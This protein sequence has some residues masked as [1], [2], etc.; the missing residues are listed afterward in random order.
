MRESIW[1]GH[2]YYCLL[3]APNTFS[4][5]LLL[6]WWFV[7]ST[8]LMAGLVC[9]QV[10][11]GSTSC[12]NLDKNFHIELFQAWRRVQAS[13]WLLLR[14]APAKAIKVLLLRSRAE[15]LVVLEI[16]VWDVSLS[17]CGNS[18]AT[19]SNKFQENQLTWTHDWINELWPQTLFSIWIY[20]ASGHCCWWC[21]W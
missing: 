21:L 10:P 8:H 18:S 20:L 14:S 5:V 6:P 1:C 11:D 17:E 3:R 4:F 12:G 9:S 13:H 15:V 16:V 19:C 2:H 7:P